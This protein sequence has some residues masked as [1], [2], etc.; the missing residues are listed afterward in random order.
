MNLPEEIKLVFYQFIVGKLPLTDFE[1]WVY[2]NEPE[3]SQ[4]SEELSLYLISFDFRQHQGGHILSH[5]IESTAIDKRDFAEWGLRRALSMIVQKENWRA[6]LFSLYHDYWDD[7]I[8][9]KFLLPLCDY[10]APAL[11]NQEILGLTGYHDEAR[12][13][14]LEDYLYPEILRETEKVLLELDLKN[15]EILSEN[16]FSCTE[17]FHPDKSRF[18]AIINQI[19]LRLA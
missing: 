19:R 18:E 1:Q 10:I 8:R 7:H 15:I 3:L 17:T 13:R 14:I 4:I 16:D 6:P 11:F 9:F 12:E 2:Q 5:Y